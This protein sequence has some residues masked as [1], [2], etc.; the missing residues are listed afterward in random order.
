MENNSDRPTGVFGFFTRL[1]RANCVCAFHEH[2]HLCVD[3]LV[4]DC[5]G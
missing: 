1:A 4:W 2:E 5:F 3:D